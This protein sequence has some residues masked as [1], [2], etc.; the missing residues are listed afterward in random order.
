MNEIPKTKKQFIREQ[1]FALMGEKFPKTFSLVEAEIKPLKVGISNDIVQSLSKTATD[2]FKKDL[3]IFLGWYVKRR[4]YHKSIVRESMRIDL[5]GN[6]VE[7]ISEDNKQHAKRKLWRLKPKENNTN[8]N[9]DIQNNTGKQKPIVVV[10]VSSI[11]VSY[12]KAKEVE[13]TQVNV[14]SLKRKLSLKKKA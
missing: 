2:E 7:P 10:P 14:N 9:N 6:E 8:Q 5:Q 3:S 4:A 11:E 13:S 1:M 12:V